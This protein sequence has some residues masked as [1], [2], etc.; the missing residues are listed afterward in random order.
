ME[1]Y[2]LVTVVKLTF[3]PLRQRAR[4]HVTGAA[5]SGLAN[6]FSSTG[7]IGIFRRSKRA[8]NGRLC[9]GPGHAIG[10]YCRWGSCCLSFPHYFSCIDL[11]NVPL[12]ILQPSLWNIP[13][14]YDRPSRWSAVSLWIDQLQLWDFYQPGHRVNGLTRL[15]MSL[16][17]GRT[18]V[19]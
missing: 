9:S 4:Q 18:C 7:P 3:L 17:L 19:S 15:P 2:H 14:P 12:L 8:M 10:H 11:P 16:Q 6:S 13:Q 1:T 5:R